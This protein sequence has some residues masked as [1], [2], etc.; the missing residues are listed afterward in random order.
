[1]H[2]GMVGLAAVAISVASCTSAT[3]PLASVSAAVIPETVTR[4]VESSSG[5][6]DVSLSF[7]I[8][9]P[10]IGSIYYSTCSAGLERQN[11]TRWELVASTVCSTY[12]SANPLDRTREIPAGSTTEAGAY[13]SGY[14]EAGMTTMIPA[15]T[16]RVR[17]S[18]L[19]RNPVAWR[20]AVGNQYKSTELTTREFALPAS[21]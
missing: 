4:K 21:N 2:A 13:M 15:G 16:Y 5:R 6:V 19:Y 1:M 11:G 3:E 14:G 9:N 8:T 18:V 20:G 17:F 10:T 7:S 12:A